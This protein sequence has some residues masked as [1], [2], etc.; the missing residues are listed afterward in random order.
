V[1]IFLL[2]V[3]VGCLSRKTTIVIVTVLLDACK[4]RNTTKYNHGFM[5]PRRRDTR[6]RCRAPSEA[7]VVY[8]EVEPLYVLH[9]VRPHWSNS[10]LTFMRRDHAD[11][12]SA[13]KFQPSTFMS[14]TSPLL[15]MSY[16]ATVSNHQL[17]S[18]QPLSYCVYVRN[19]KSCFVLCIELSHVHVILLVVCPTIRQHPFQS[20]F[21]ARFHDHTDRPLFLLTSLSHCVRLKH[22]VHAGTF[23]CTRTHL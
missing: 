3:I 13:H 21:F 5:S 1:F 20:K 15:Q 18:V 10:G 6:L 16:S 14:Y 11:F 9:S 12:T 19:N 17:V 22:I 2:V 7:L 23:P 4:S 8:S